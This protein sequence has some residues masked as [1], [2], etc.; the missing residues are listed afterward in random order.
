MAKIKLRPSAHADLKGIASHTQDKWGRRKRDA[1]LGKLNERLRRLAENPQIGLVRDDVR[2]G[3]R[4]A[5][6]GRHLIF[7][8]DIDGGIEVVR[9]LHENMDV[10]RH[11]EGRRAKER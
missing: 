2:H 11:L 9:I 10:K 6:A 3:Y 1:Y 8:R 7:Y 4:S 5:K